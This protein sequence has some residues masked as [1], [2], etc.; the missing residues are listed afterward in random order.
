MESFVGEDFDSAAVE[1]RNDDRVNADVREEKA[2][3]LC[4]LMEATKVNMAIQFFIIARVFYGK[5]KDTA[6]PSDNRHSTCCMDV[7]LRCRCFVLLVGGDSFVLG[8]Q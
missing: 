5:A 1:N 8:R 3:E 2:A 7:T 4:T 6:P